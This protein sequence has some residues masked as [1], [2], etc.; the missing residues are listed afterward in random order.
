VLPDSTHLAVDA[1]AKFGREE[2]LAYA[3]ALAPYGLRWFEE[4]CDPND[5]G[6]MAELAAAYAPPLAT[7]EDLYG[8]QDV[9]NLVRFGGWRP[10]R[11]L[12]Q[13]DPP[14]SY[15]LDAYA[16][17]VLD[18]EQQGWDA[19]CHFPHGGNQMSLAVVAGLGLGGCEAYPGVFGAFGGFA[20]AAVVEGGFVG[21]PQLPGI[22]F[23]GHDAL[24]ALM[25]T[26]GA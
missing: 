16:T 23:E 22:G 2:A 12:V 1:N 6:V 15:G 4:P 10:G 11:D 20:D 21:V 7:G 14:Q 25:K 8:A 3:R 26:V 5:F 17:L 24:Y 19:R 18:L 13:V 9:L